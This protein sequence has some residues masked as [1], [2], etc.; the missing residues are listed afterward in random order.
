MFHETQKLLLALLHQTVTFIKNFLVSKYY[1]LEPTYY[2]IILKALAQFR[3]LQLENLKE[4]VFFLLLDLSY[5]K[6]G[7]GVSSSKK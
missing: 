7:R 6:T 4:N 1:P 2:E 5:C 3:S